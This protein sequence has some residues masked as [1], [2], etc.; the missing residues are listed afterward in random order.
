[1]NF[2]ANVTVCVLY[3]TRWLGILF[4]IIILVQHYYFPFPAYRLHESFR[5][6]PHLPK[7]TATH[8]P[9]KCITE[10]IL[11]AHTFSTTNHSRNVHSR[12]VHPCIFDR[13]T[14]FTPAISVAPPLCGQQ[15][16]S[17]LTLLIFG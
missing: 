5:F 14:M 10:T 6:V 11:C 4:I 12:D 1:V 9:T 3:F 8:R 17:Y 15:H 2:A 7:I 16:D 13:V